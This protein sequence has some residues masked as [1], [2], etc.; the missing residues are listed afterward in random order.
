MRQLLRLIVLKIE[1]F[2]HFL[3]DFLAPSLE[4]EKLKKKDYS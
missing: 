3:G 4:E 1:I 2:N